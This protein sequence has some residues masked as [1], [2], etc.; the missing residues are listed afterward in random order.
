MSMVRNTLTGR[1]M[2]LSHIVWL[3]VAL[4]RAGAM[5]IT[6]AVNPA[7]PFHILESP[8]QGQG[9]CDVLIERISHYLPDVEHAVELMPQK[10]VG[11]SFEAD[12][13]LCFPCMIHKPNEPKADTLCQPMLIVLMV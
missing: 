9:I 1:G 5:E 6:W 3:L 10:R 11:L 2:L 8:M 4:P 13:N 7:P 12:K